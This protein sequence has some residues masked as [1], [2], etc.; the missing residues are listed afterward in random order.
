MAQVLEIVMSTSSE[1]AINNKLLE[2]IQQAL[3]NSNDNEKCFHNS[4]NSFN[5]L[6]EQL[7]NNPFLEIKTLI[8]KLIS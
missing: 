5:Y 1:D 2:L 3:K 6:T 7:T 8:L 4:I